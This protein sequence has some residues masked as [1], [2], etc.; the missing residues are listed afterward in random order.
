M[1]IEGVS[2]RADKVYQTMKGMGALGE[3]KMLDAE[4]ITNS[5]KMPKGQVMACLQ[6]LEG[7]GYIKRRAR[8]KAA[9]YYITK[10]V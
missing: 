10:V 3:E 5:S 7:K 6:E 1:G 4:R 9:G 2:D 8:D